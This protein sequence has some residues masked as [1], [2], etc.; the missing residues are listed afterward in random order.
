MRRSKTRSVRAYLAG[1]KPS[2]RSRVYAAERRI[3]GSAQ[4]GMR[5]RRREYLVDAIFAVENE[6]E[7]AGPG[8]PDDPRVLALNAARQRVE[9]DLGWSDGHTIGRTVP[10]Q[11]PRGAV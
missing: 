2:T 1:V 9:A 4:R 7:S 8:H 10:A 5:D 11:T 3:A 6:I